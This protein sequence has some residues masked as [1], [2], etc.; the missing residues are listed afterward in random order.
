MATVRLCRLCRSVIRSH[1]YASVFSLS[2]TESSKWPTRIQDLLEVR[3]DKDDGLPGYVCSSCKRR[4]EVLEKAAADLVEVQR[5]A[6]AVYDAL[7]TTRGRLKRTKETSGLVGV[8]CK[9]QI[10]R[11]KVPRWSVV[12][13]FGSGKSLKIHA[14]L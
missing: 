5:Q 4:V 13:L 11:K 9:G 3:V 2:S 8:H 6:K 10:T 1:H 7:C 14:I 12:G